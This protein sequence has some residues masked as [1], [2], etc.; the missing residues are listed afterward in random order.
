MQTRPRTPAAVANAPQRT[1]GGGALRPSPTLSG[2][3]PAAAAAPSLDGDEVSIETSAQPSTV[4]QCFPDNAA[5]QRLH[6]ATRHSRARLL[7]A[8]TV[9][10]YAERSD[11]DPATAETPSEKTARLIR[12]CGRFPVI[13]AKAESGELVRVWARCKSRLCPTCGVIRARQLRDD[14]REL[15]KS[16]DAPKLLTL[17][18]RSSDAPLGDQV[19]TLRASLKRLRRSKAWKRHVRGG[20]AVIEVTYNAA[21]G[22]WHP[23]LHLLVDGSYWRQAKIADLW[24]GITGSSRI[25][26]VRA[27][28]DRAAAVGYCLKYVLKTQT[29]PDVPP[30]RLSE[31]VV[32]MKGQR[33][34]QTFGTLHGQRCGGG[35]RECGG[36]LQPVMPLLPLL[37]AADAGEASAAVLLARLTTATK[38][39]DPAADLVLSRDLL[40]WWEGK[41]AQE[42]EGCRMPSPPPPK[43]KHK[44]PGQPPLPPHLPWQIVQLNSK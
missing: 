37:R 27:V 4:P 42:A 9:A 43:V 15:V 8:L 5:Q 34:A 22:Q 14:L 32:A 11:A 12:S 33:M 18:L 1:H 21:R 23:H 3:V 16:I 10:S 31:W 40:H 28:H 29:M 41:R 24:E 2:G 13:C 20:L 38:T 6:A 35:R 19:A 17:T 7:E 30:A 39:P 26:D 44:P 36:G 25:V